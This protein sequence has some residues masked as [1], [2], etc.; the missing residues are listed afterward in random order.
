MIIGVLESDWEKRGG[1][2]FL[3]AEE[4]HLESPVLF[5]I[6]AQKERAA[7]TRCS[8]ATSRR[9]ERKR[10]GSRSLLQLKESG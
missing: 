4:L 7:K 10:E 6:G 1:R 3:G 5:F 9:R 8:L 2:N